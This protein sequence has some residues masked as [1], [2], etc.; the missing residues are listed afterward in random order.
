LV[1]NLDASRKSSYNTGTTWTDISGS[2][3][4]GT[5]VN[6]VGYTSSN[7]GGLT[8]NGTNQY[9]TLGN[10]KLRYTDN[11][12]VESIFKVA[13]LPTNVG[14]YCGAKYPIISNW[15]WGYNMFV[16]SNGKASI[17]VYSGNSES[18]QIS[19]IQSVVGS[20]VHVAFKKSGTSLSLYLNGSLVE[21]KTMTSNNVY[22]QASYPFTIGGYL[23]C[24]GEYFYGKSTIGIV[25]VYSKALSDAEVL[26]NFNA[27]KSRFGL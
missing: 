21:T 20:F 24:G 12:T 22:Y 23:G 11:F 5:L 15:D 17:A 1:L 3:N 16:A 26:Q 9:V 13:D 7:S 6:G 2:G 27:T 19:T 25:R 18:T 8:F 4:N 14:T 10:D